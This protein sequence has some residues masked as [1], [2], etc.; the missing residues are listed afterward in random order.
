MNDVTERL[1]ETARMIETM[2]PPYTGFVLLA[3]DFNA[4]P[5]T[6]R[7]QYVSNGNREDVVKAMREFINKTENG[8]GK[9]LP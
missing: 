2:L 9:D 5:N 1:Q 4:A 7:L 6:S 8:W 3:F